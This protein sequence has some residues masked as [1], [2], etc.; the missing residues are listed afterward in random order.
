[1]KKS[2][3]WL[4]SL[5]L[6][7][8]LIGCREHE[9]PTPTVNTGPVIK[10]IILQDAAIRESGCNSYY[11][12]NNAGGDG[13]IHTCA[14]TF[15]N[16]NFGAA[17]TWMNFDLSSIPTGATILTAELRLYA[18]TT[19][20]YNGSN[21]HSSL[22]GT[23]EWAIKRVTSDWKENTL[24]WNNRPTYDD[25]GA[26]DMA[27]SVSGAQSYTVDIASFLNDQLKHPNLYYGIMFQIK[28]EVP[29]RLIAFCSKEHIYGA[30]LKPILKITYQ[31]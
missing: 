8:Q 18:D 3:L 15:N 4:G 12:N 11:P 9:C 19:Y 10:Q 28:T 5:L 14:W 7:L 22:T 29:Y 27:E 16:G 25:V 6:T 24:T 21:G 26:I 2:F 23:N 17:R 30:T 20:I 1:M 31:K 13:R